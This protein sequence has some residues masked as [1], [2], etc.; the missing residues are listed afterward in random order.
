MKT[1]FYWAGI[2]AFGQ[3]CENTVE[4]DGDNIGK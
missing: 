1:S 3:R 2:H 4:K